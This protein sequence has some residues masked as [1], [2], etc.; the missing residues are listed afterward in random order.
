MYKTY[1]PPTCNMA[2]R[3]K[4]TECSIKG[5][6]NF[7]KYSTAIISV[8]NNGFPLGKNVSFYSVTTFFCAVDNK[9]YY[10]QSCFYLQTKD[11]KEITNKHIQR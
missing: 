7:K 5:L 2:V 10:E 9:K 4:A 1:L 11:V 6:E 8:T 3:N